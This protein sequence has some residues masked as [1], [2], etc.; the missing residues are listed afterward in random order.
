LETALNLVWLGV[1][2]ALLIACGVHMSR[3]GEDRS[4]AMAVIALVCLIC[5]LFPVISMT[6]DLNCTGPAL[7]ETS[8][9]KKLA[10]SA[11]VVLTLLSW[12][13]LLQAP[14]ENRWAA[15]DRAPDIRRPLQEV[16]AFSLNRRPPPLLSRLVL[17]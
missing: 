1:S 17:S 6:D 7:V 16:F 8:K 4:R 3:A 10:A 13:A 15:P 12:P 2:A 5:L 9:L 11:H 14:Q